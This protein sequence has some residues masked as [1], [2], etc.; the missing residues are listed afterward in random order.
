MS[1]GVYRRA[2]CGAEVFSSETKYDSDTGSPSSWE[3]IERGAVELVE[4][5][6]LW[7]R[8]TRGHVHALRGPP[9]ACLSGW[10]ATDGRSLSHEL[11]RAEARPEH[12]RGP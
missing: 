11:G 12:A 6:S 8:G 9:R 4:D 10:P 1:P 3:P 2:G 5:G 7:M